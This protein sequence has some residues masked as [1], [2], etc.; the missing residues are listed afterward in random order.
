MVAEVY[1]FVHE[2][3]HGYIFCKS[4]EELI[5]HRIKVEGF[6]KSRT[7]NNIIAKNRT[8]AHQKILI[9]ICALGAS[10]RKWKLEK[11]FIETWKPE[12]C[13]CVEK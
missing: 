11:I 4:L 7:L 5:I 1:A 13:R 10:N 2:F 8:M 6:I 12:R 9:D 3:Y